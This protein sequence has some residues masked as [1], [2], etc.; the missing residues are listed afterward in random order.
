MFGFFDQH[1]EVT[2]PGTWAFMF[3]NLWNNKKVP[4]TEAQAAKIIDSLEE[5]LRRSCDQGN[6]E[7]FDPWRAQMAAGMLEQ[8]YRRENKLVEAERVIRAYG[9]A[10]ESVAALANPTLA[11]A[12]LQ[13]VFEAYRSRGMAGDAE[14]VQLALIEKGKDLQRDMQAIEIPVTLPKEKVDAFLN[15]LVDGGLEQALAKIAARFIPKAQKAREQSEKSLSLAPLQALI[16]IVIHQAETG[17][18]VAKIGGVKE[19]PEGRLIYQLAQN[20]EFESAFLA[21]GLDKVRDRYQLSAEQLV[22]ILFGSPLFGDERRALLLE[23]I[24]AYYGVDH[25][26]AVHLLVPQIEQ[27]MRRLLDAFGVPANKAGKVIGT[28]QAK[29][30]GDILWE[31]RIVEF[32]PD[33]LRLYLIAFLADSRGHNLR[34]RLSHGL[35]THQ[36][37]QRPISDRVVHVLLCLALM[38]KKAGPE[39]EPEK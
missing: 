19:D 24:C 33:D 5:F 28:M 6:N 15:A 29:N 23:G 31:E 1:A 30:L 9:Q 27:A 11:V 35:L 2:K 3:E 21:G 26:K 17:H 22:D 25:V 10:F 37:L 13:P 14:R 39:T 20:V 8:H 34:N 4:V 16:P 38:F 36:E 12:W 18:P 32:V 7:E